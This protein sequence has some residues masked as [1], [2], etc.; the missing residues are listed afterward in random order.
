MDWML[1][2]ADKCCVRWL[3]LGGLLLPLGCVSQS[4]GSLVI[5]VGNKQ[6]WRLR[7]SCEMVGDVI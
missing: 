3:S 4:V 6:Y 5:S 7:Y 2:L 1:Q